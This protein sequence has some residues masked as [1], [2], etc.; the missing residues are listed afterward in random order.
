MNTKIA[1]LMIEK[2]MTAT[3]HQTLGH[4]REV[5]SVHAVSCMPVVGP[6]GEPLGIVT[7]TDLLDCDHSESAPL[8]GV[9]SKGVYTVPQYSDPSMAA[10]IMRNHHVHHVLVTHEGQL[11]GIVSSFDL[12]RLVEDH[13]F[14]MKNAP[15]TSK[16]HGGKR[17]K[18]EF[19]GEE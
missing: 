4:V 7:T 5:M 1:D 6:D 3:P 13:R 9:M 11:V 10:R 17:R 18:E 12:L 14:T 19:A 2:V 8:S 15:T 16:K